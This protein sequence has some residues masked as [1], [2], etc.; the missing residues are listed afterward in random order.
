[1]QQLLPSPTSLTPQSNSNDVGN[2]YGSNGYG[3]LGGRRTMAT[4][5]MAMETKRVMATATTW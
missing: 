3:N 4:I 5:E 1:L 2:G